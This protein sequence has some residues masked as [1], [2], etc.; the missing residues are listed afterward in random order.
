[1]SLPVAPDSSPAPLASD[2]LLYQVKESRYAL[3]VLHK[4]LLDAERARYERANGRVPGPGALLQL[5]L[6]DP[7]FAWLRP[8]STL[9]V[10]IDE[11]MDAKEPV[12]TIEAERLL[13]EIRAVIQL[14]DAVG[15]FQQRYRDVEPEN[16][17][18]PAAYATLLARLGA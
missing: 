9:V 2:A 8:I 18:V 13:A 5:V 7:W 12:Q 11:R 14:D 10:Q 6:N 15:P 4:K 3:L 1:M 17:E 16:A